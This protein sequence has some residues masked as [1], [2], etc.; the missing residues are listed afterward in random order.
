MPVACF[1][2]SLVTVYIAV[3]HSTTFTFWNTVVNIWR[4]SMECEVREQTIW[5]MYSKV[6]FKKYINDLF[7]GRKPTCC[8]SEKK[9]SS[10]ELVS[11]LSP[12]K[13]TL[14]FNCLPIQWETDKMYN[15]QLCQSQ[16]CCTYGYRLI[17]LHRVEYETDSIRR[18]S[19]RSTSCHNLTTKKNQSSTYT[20]RFEDLKGT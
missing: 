4:Y 3:S 11:K 8:S 20:C 19:S 15:S 10:R 7:D 16:L 1:S 17:S 18:L 13:L 6:H 14:G 9:H 2:V 12:A 5:L